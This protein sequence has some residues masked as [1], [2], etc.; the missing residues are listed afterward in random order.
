VKFFA[1]TALRALLCLIPLSLPAETSAPPFRVTPTPNQTAPLGTEETAFKEDRISLQVVSGALFSP[2]GVGPDAPTFN[3][4]QTNLR[5]GWMLNTPNPEGG[6]FAGNWEALIELSGSGIF[7][8]PGDIIIGPTALVRYNFV[9]PGWKVVPYVQGGV[10]IV[11]TDAYEDRTQD[12]I[13]QAIEFTPQAS[14]GLRVLVAEDWSVDL[15]G[16]FH[17]I[18]NAGMSE[19]NDGT[20]ALGGLI[21]ATYR[22]DK[23]WE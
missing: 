22:F 7:D 4:A 20:N 15:E 13:G 9:Q 6:F 11:Y 23:V 16:M 3:Y 8:G 5:L 17:H 2:I 12:A 14:V 18:S 1:Q 19:R 21:G 10:G